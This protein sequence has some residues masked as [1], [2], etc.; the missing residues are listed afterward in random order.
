MPIMAVQKAHSEHEQVHAS[1]RTRKASVAR[2]L[3][4]EAGPNNVR[5]R[6]RT[7]A[8]SADPLLSWLTFCH[9]GAGKADHPLAGTLQLHAAGRLGCWHRI[10]LYDRCYQRGYQCFSSEHMWTSP[11]VRGVRQ[12]RTCQQ[13]HVPQICAPHQGAPSGRRAYS[14]RCLSSGQHQ[15]RCQHQNRRFLAAS[16]ERQNIRHRHLVIGACQPAPASKPGAEVV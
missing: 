2:R 5:S 6:P 15:I 4:C 11:S 8:S 13:A 7:P 3:V 10:V 12:E 1:V 14:I 16:S 9:E